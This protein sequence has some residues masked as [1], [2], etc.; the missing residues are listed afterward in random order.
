M[1]VED[2]PP[3]T[4]VGEVVTETSFI[5]VTKTALCIEL[6]FSVAVMLT[7][8]KISTLNVVTGNWAVVCPAGTV[9]VAGTDAVTVSELERD[10]LLSMFEA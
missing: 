8:F 10:T 5:G 9:T 6:L 4:L 3:I 1:P 2:L 7:L